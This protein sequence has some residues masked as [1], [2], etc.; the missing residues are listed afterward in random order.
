H[1]RWPRDWSSDVCS[2]D[3]YRAPLKRAFLQ[4]LVTRTSPVRLRNTLCANVRFLCRF[5]VRFLR[6]AAR[7][8]CETRSLRILAGSV[9]FLCTAFSRTRLRAVRLLAACVRAVRAV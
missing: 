3:L 1:T 4:L 7:V 2:S 6:A 8:A 9:P 5:T